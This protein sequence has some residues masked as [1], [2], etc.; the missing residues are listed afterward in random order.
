MSKTRRARTSAGGGT[1]RCLGGWMNDG[2]I[3]KTDTKR[4]VDRRKRGRIVVTTMEVEGSGQG[5]GMFCVVFA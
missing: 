4:K 1:A 3:I 2:K 5:L